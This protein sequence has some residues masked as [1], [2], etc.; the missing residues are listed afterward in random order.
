MANILNYISCNESIEKSNAVIVGFPFDGTSSYRPGSRFAPQA[1]REASY[2]LECYSPYLDKDLEDYKIFD[3]GDLEF[4]FGDKHKT[5][6]MISGAI[7]EYLKGGKK[8]LSIGGEHLITLP[9]I[10]EYYK[11]FPDLQLIHFDAHC[12]LREDYLGEELSHATVL[13]QIYK[14]MPMEQIFHFGIRSGTKEEWDFSKQLNFY[15]FN[16]DKFQD[17]L[18]T[19]DPSK[20]IY[21]TLDLDILDPAYLPGTGTPEPGGI[22]I[23]E[24][25]SA[26]QSLSRFNLIGCDIV[27]L[28]PDYDPSK[29]SSV[30]AAKVIRE[31][32]IQLCI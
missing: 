31:L 26:I 3:A 2:G 6:M 25:F 30:L 18:N 15:P 20:P 24:L 13:R 21:F 14:F 32:L 7:S 9:I 19:I 22:T 12:D 8:I 4:P 28:A 17:V 23:T 5:L 27:E 1:I 16:L 11:H 10:E 29:T